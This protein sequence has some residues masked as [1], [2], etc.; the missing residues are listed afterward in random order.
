MRRSRYSP[1]WIQDHKTCL[2]ATGVDPL[3]NVTIDN[4]KASINA[5]DLLRALAANEFA[6]AVGNT[7]ANTRLSDLVTNDETIRTQFVNA[8]GIP[9][10]TRFMA[11]NIDSAEIQHAAC[12]TLCAIAMHSN[13]GIQVS[14]SEAEA[15]EAIADALKTHTTEKELQ[16]IGIKTLH[17]H[18]RYAALCVHI[19]EEEV[20]QTLVAAFHAAVAQ[21]NLVTCL[22]DTFTAVASREKDVRM[23]I[24]GTG[25]IQGM[26]STLGENS[27]DKEVARAVTGALACMLEDISENRD[28]FKTVGGIESLLSVLKVHGKEEKVLYN[29]LIALKVMLSHSKEVR[30]NIIEGVEW[31]DHLIPC[32][33]FPDDVG[34]FQLGVEILIMLCQHDM[35]QGRL[36]AIN[37]G[38]ALVKNDATLM[39]QKGLVRA[40]AENRGNLLKIV[41]QLRRLLVLSDEIRSNPKIIDCMLQIIKITT[42]A[43]DKFKDDIDILL[44]MIE[45]Q[46]AII[47]GHDNCKAEFIND[48]GIQ[49]IV[50]LMKRH[51]KDEKLNTICC[52][53]LDFSAEGQLATAP[54]LLKGKEIAVQAILTSVADFAECSALAESALSLL[55]KVAAIS[56]EDTEKLVACGARTMVQMAQSKHVGNPAIESLANQLLILLVDNSLTTNNGGNGPRGA[57]GGMRARSRSRVI[58]NSESVRARAQKSRSPVRVHRSRRASREQRMAAAKASVGAVDDGKIVGSRV[59]VR[60]ATRQ[61]FSLE[62]VLE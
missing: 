26:L 61:K 5:T 41:C 40:I 2:Q 49:S 62:P 50:N 9:L 58:E 27:K 37:I 35:D 43:L 16:A 31:L 56:A 21:P 36:G 17:A 13:N 34:V 4:L 38:N 28:C 24:G 20:L 33:A 47:S 44:E 25:V 6:N 51:R 42:T 1:S 12:N 54:T 60:R 8:G 46:S 11:I 23:T 19:A 7:T 14:L 10:L 45:L 3:Q 30:Q 52:K 59:R 22:A 39:C 15:I 18:S 29:E 32:I 48:G 55:I 53:V 57:K